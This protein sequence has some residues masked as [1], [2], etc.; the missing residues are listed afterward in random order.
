[1]ADRENR[2]REKERRKETKH[3]SLALP[4]SLPLSLLYEKI[5]FSI[6]S[7]SSFLWQMIDVFEKKSDEPERIFEINQMKILTS[8]R[9][10]TLI[11][12]QSTEPTI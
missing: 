5:I 6:F 7:S 2:E 4:P 10:S 3:F 12:I 1:M 9:T 8:S 11:N